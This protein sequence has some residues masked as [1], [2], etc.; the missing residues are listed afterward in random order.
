MMFRFL[1]F[2]VLFGLCQL[3]LHLY[4]RLFPG[5][6]SEMTLDTLA[7]FRM[8]LPAF[9]ASVVVPMFA[10]T[11]LARYGTRKAGFILYFVWLF[12]MIFLP[13]V[14]LAT[15]LDTGA[16]DRMAYAIHRAVSAAP[17]GLV[18]G[19]ILALL[20]VITAYIWVSGKKIMVK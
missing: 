16:L 18:L 6:Q 15:P 5:I 4:P 8:M 7:L 2:A 11:L 20:A 17:Y 9:L 3:E 12:S 10:G 19:V 13:K 14:F 1:Y